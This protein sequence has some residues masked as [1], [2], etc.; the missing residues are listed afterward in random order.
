MPASPPVPGTGRATGVVITGTDAHLIRADA[1]VI[2]GSRGLRITGLPDDKAWT[3]RDRVHAAIANSGQPQPPD[4]IAVTIEAENPARHG[5]GAALAIAIA[6]FIAAG[7]LPADA[8]E[9]TVLAA[10]LGLDGGL[11]PAREN[12]PVLRAATAAGYR[13]VMVAAGGVAL[14]APPAGLTVIQCA[15]LSDAVSW[16]ATHPPLPV[17]VQ[18]AGSAGGARTGITSPDED[19]RIACAVL[20]HLAEPSRP[21]LRTLLQVL[22][23]TEILSAIRSGSLPDLVAAALRPSVIRRFRTALNDW[24]DQLADVRLSPEGLRR[25]ADRGV[26]L[27]CPGDPDWPAQLGDLGSAAPPALWAR[28]AAGL[29]ACSAQA[30]A[31]IGSRAATSYG[32]HVSSCIAQ[33]LSKAGW[34]VVSGGAYGIDAAAHNGAQVND[35]TT[36]A[37]LACGPDVAYPRQHRGLLDAIAAQGTILSEWPPGSVPSRQRFLLRNRLVA[38]LARAVVVVEAAER[39]GTMSTVRQAEELGRPILAVPG[40]VTSATSAGCN[41]LTRTGRAICVTSAADIIGHLD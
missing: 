26:S 37:V 30:V 11:R 20:T 16:L 18:L 8:A 32:T 35:G 19:T 21:L 15:S 27:I 9:G 24:R 7:A 29:A 41:L 17:T 13:R 1:T 28:G 39:S 34:T 31:V 22:E 10:E 38:T 33:G 2:P 36:V 25:L 6:A 40:P 23:P 3:T 12:G 4:M 14:S 5:T